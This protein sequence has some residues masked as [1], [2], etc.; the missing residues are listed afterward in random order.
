MRTKMP[1]TAAFI[2]SMRAAFG[3]DAINVQIKAGMK[4]QPTFWA[5]ENGHTVGT[6][7]P[8]K[9]MVSAADMEL[10]SFHGN[11]VQKRKK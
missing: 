3:T 10:E 7:S 1:L 11:E 9:P 6:K 8:V 2:D 4:G 5:K